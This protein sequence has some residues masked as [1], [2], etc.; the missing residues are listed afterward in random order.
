LDLNQ[1]TPEGAAVELN[2]QIQGFYNAAKPDISG[3]W[4]MR[5]QLQLMFPK[6]R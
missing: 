4:S 3:R 5:V 2:A 1:L 6:S